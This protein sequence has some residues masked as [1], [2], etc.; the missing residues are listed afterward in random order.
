MLSPGFIHSYRQGKLRHA[1]EAMAKKNHFTMK[2]NPPLAPTTSRNK[3]ISQTAYAKTI[4]LKIR[5]IK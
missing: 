5:V 3:I 1:S 4:K 2:E